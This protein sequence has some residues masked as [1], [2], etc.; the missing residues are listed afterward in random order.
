MLLSTWL[1][2]FFVVFFYPLLLQNNLKRQTQ[3]RGRRHFQVQ[4]GIETTVSIIYLG[5]SQVNSE[6]NDFIAHYL[7][8]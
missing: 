7:M 4:H 8:L 3:V 2:C 5:S 1:D 6:S